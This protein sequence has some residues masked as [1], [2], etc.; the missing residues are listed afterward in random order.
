MTNFLLVHLVTKQYSSI[1]HRGIVQTYSKIE[2]KSNIIDNMA[3]LLENIFTICLVNAFLDGKDVHRMVCVNSRTR[4]AQYKTIITLH[5]YFRNNKIDRAKFIFDVYCTIGDAVGA[6]IILD[7]ACTSI[8]LKE[9]LRSACYHGRD[10]IVQMVIAMGAQNYDE[11]FI[12]ACSN[13]NNNRLV[14]HLVDLGQK[15][16][17]VID[18]VEGFITACQHYCHKLARQLAPQVLVPEGQDPY[19]VRMKCN[20]CLKAACII[21]C[22][23]LVKFFASHG[24]DRFNG[25]L[26][27]VSESHNVEIARFLL[28]PTVQGSPIGLEM[29]A[30]KLD[31]PLHSACFYGYRDLI[32]LL[33]SHAHAKHI[34]L[35]ISRGIAGACF[36]QRIEYVQ[37]MIDLAKQS[38]IKINY[39]RGF[40]DACGYC[41]NDAI[42]KLLIEN[43]A[44]CF[45]EGLVEACIYGHDDIVKL[46]IKHGADA[47]NQGLMTC[48]RW[49]QL[50]MAQFILDTATN[51]PLDLNEALFEALSRRHFDMAQL[52]VQ[53]GATNIDK[54]TNRVLCFYMPNERAQLCA[55]RA[56]LMSI[57]STK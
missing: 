9:C 25:A 14:D 36:G 54:A 30:T 37:L 10:R 24:A 39:S 31:D 23:D 44:D 56:T 34:Q 50:K 47:F 4:S 6:R 40:R 35:D 20:K 27:I 29:G 11:G 21:E 52:M 48:C 49:G 3:H 18:F 33:V 55:T 19:L 26:R 7:H 51:I 12:A 8:D 43:G 41:H 17:L 16:G 45:N 2:F 13:K 15:N 32:D 57:Q 1:Y 22:L 42:V 46:M 53:Y 5:E 38:G 28:E